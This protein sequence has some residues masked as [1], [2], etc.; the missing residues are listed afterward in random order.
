M[1][2][3]VSEEA[4]IA[5]IDHSIQT[6][7]IKDVNKLNFFNFVDYFKKLMMEFPGV[8]IDGMKNLSG[9]LT[10]SA[11][12]EKAKDVL[13]I[14]VGIIEDLLNF[15]EI[16]V[17]M[18]DRQLEFLKRTNCEIVNHELKKHE[19]MLMLVSVERAMDSEGLRAKIMTLRKYKD[20]EVC[21]QFTLKYSIWAN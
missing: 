2:D 5:P 13:V 6:L 7:V 14:K 18:S 10:V 15:M 11:T 3:T 4:M 9:E 12:A 20:Y 21:K 1:M 8:Q 16:E 17:E 19:A